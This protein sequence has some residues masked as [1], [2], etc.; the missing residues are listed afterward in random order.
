MGI[1]EGFFFLIFR[2]VLLLL[3]FFED[4]YFG[5]LAFS[6]VGAGEAFCFGRFDY[7]LVNGVIR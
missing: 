4:A 7:G 1:V 6:G 2:I 3:F 5:V